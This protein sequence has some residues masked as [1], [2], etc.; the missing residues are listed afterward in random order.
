MFIRICGEI[1]R[2]QD[3]VLDS[4]IQAMPRTEGE[5]DVSDVGPAEIGTL[6]FDPYLCL[7]V[8]ANPPSSDFTLSL[9][10]TTD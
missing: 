7:V 9:G 10:P 6:T 2:E 1:R 3:D 5:I 8:H 4:R